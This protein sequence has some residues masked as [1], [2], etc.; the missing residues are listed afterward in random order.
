MARTRQTARKSTGGKAPRK[1]VSAQFNNQSC[2]TPSN[3]NSHSATYFSWNHGTSK[4]SVQSQNTPVSVLPYSKEVPDVHSFQEEPATLSDLLN[5]DAEYLV[6]TSFNSH[7]FYQKQEHPDKIFSLSVTTCK[8]APLFGAD[9]AKEHWLS[10]NFNSKFDGDGI[11]KFGRSALNLVVALDISGSMSNQFEGEEID[12]NASS[13]SKLKIAKECVL[14]LLSQLKED[15]DSFGL[16]VFTEDVFVIHPLK[17]WKSSDKPTLEKAINKLRAT[18]STNL[19]K[20]IKFA[21]SQYEKIAEQRNSSNRI[22]L[23]TDMELKEPSDDENLL[24]E[25]TSNSQNAIWTSVV[26]IGVD[27]RQNLIQQI[28]KTAGANYSSVRS[29]SSFKELIEK[30]FGYFLDFFFLDGLIFLFFYFATY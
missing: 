30:E 24:K 25:V 4:S 11:Q 27:L 8:L 20:A 23:L 14:A 7:F 2:A 26:G 19:T 6:E 10:L 16:V 12:Q 3:T 9:I 28:S 22:F 17:I 13:P 5:V 18:G 15:I 29:T 21:T 1:F